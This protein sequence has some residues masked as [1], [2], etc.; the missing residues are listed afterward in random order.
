MDARA[1]TK[2]LG[3]KWQSSFGLCR[4]PVH[5]DKTPSLK[6]RD[7]ARKE[8]GIDLHC[9]A[10]CD[11]K[12]IKDEFKRQGLLSEFAPAKIDRTLGASRETLA[13]PTPTV[14]PDDN[15]KLLRADNIWRSAKPL[16][17]TL[18]WKYFT[19]RR[20]L[21]LG[22]LDDLSHCLRWHDGLCAV[23]ALMT[24]PIGNVPCG[25]HRTFLN[26]DGTKRER[27][28]LGKQGIVRVSPDEDVTQ[29]LGIAEG[30]EDALAILI[31]GW[32]PV[33]AA[34][35]AGGIERFPILGGIEF[36]TIFAD[37]DGA[38]QKAAE[39]CATRWTETGREARISILEVTP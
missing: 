1:I 21:H 27:K 22:A 36:L 8:D 30:V 35:S 28:M 24:T 3:G 37:N 6:V 38:G 15:G 31:S 5:A 17:D 19:E 20:G 16:R 2:A 34:T 7:D 9:F 14:E 13:P 29:G 11:W 23:I 33:W 26:K 10:G 18:G 4:C 39:A 12:D 25:V 32:A